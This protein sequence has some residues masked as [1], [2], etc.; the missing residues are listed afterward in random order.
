MPT[1]LFA[2]T[3]DEVMALRKNDRLH[4]GKFSILAELGRKLS[5]P[6]EAEEEIEA[7]C[8]HGHYDRCER[9]S[10]AIIKDELDALTRT[11]RE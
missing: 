9:R 3:L 10:L 6:G 11:W 4:R 7:L 8:P 2:Y 1:A 5:V